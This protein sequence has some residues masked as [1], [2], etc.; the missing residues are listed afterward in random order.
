MVISILSSNSLS[1]SVFTDEIS[2][3]FVVWLGYLTPKLS[4]NS[5]STSMRETYISK[6]F[7]TKSMFDHLLKVLVLS[8]CEGNQNTT[9]FHVATMQEREMPQIDNK[10]AAS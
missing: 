3:N 7:L 8:I 5:P 10:Q 9:A 6:S 4:Y 1:I 2:S